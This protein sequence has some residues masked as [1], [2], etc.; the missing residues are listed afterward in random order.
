[1]FSCRNRR[2]KS[3]GDHWN[4]LPRYHVFSSFHGP[5][6][7]NGFLSHLHNHFESKGITTFNDQ[8]IE[9]G[10][11]IGPELVQAIRESRVSIVVLSEKY[12]SSGWCLDELVE[13][14]KCKEASGQA[15]L[16]IFYK[17]D[18]S[19][20]RKQRGD[21][22]NTFKK[23]C[24]GK[25]EE[26]KQRWIKA[27]TD[28]A[29]IAGEHSLN[30]ANEAEMIQ[31]IATDVSNKL[32]VTPSRDFEGMVGLEA[33]L[34]K[35][36][37]LLCLE[38]NDVKMIGIWGPAGIG[39]TTI[40]RA[41]FN[42]LSTGFRHSCFMGN[43]DV[44]NYDSKLRLHNMLLSKILNQK[45]MKIHHLG[46]IKEW[47]HNQRVL[48]VL[49]DVDD[50]E[51]LE[52]LAKESF[53]FG[54]RSRIIVTLKDKKILKA[55][56]INDIYHVDYPSKKEAL[57]IFCLSAFKQSSPQDGFEEFA[58]KVVELCGNLPLALCVVGS[59]FYGESEDEWRLQLY[60][61]EINLD[62][63]VE[64]VLR[65]GY[66]KLLE[67]HQ[68]LF[69]HIACFFN[70][71]SV[72]YVSTM[73]ADS[74]LDVENGLKN[75]AAKSL[76]HIST[77][78]RI[79][80]HCLLQQLGRHVVVQQSGEQ[81]KRQFLVEAKEIRDVLANKT[82]TGSVIGISFDMSKIGEF[83]ISKRAFERMCNL[84]FLKFY[85]GNVSLL[86]DM[87]YLPRLRLLHWDS[88]PR[89]SLPLT[90][91]PECLVELHMRYSKL[92][93]LWGGIQPL[94]NLKKIDLGY[95]FNL[96]EIPNLSKATNLETLKL[97]GCE[98]LVVLPSSIRNLHKLEMLDA[99]GCSKLQVIPTNIDLASLEEVKMD[100]C[101]R[102][103]SF[104]DI[105]RNIEYLSVA[106]TKIKEFPASIVGYWSRL[107]IL[108]IGSRSLK[109]LTHVPQSVKSLDLSN[110]DIKMIPDY[111][112][113]LPHLG[114]L[115]VDNCRKLVSIQGHFPSLA[116]LSAEHCISLKSVCCSFHRPISNLMFH[117]CLKLDNASKRG[118]VQLSG[119]KSIC[120]PGKEIPAEFTHQTR[121][122]SITISL[123]PGGKEVFSVFSRFKAC[124][125]LSPI[126]NFAFNKINCIL[127]SREGVKINCTTQSIYTFV[128]GRSLSEHL[129]MFCGDLFPEENGCLMD[130]T[131]NE[132][133]FEFS[134]SDDNVMAC[135]VKILA[136]DGQSSS[137][138][139]VGY[140]ETEGNRNHRIDGE[141]KALKV[142]QVNNIKNS[143]HTGD[144]SWLR[145]LLLGKK[146]MKR[147]KTELSLTPVSG[148]SDDTQG[149]LMRYHHPETVQL[150]KEENTTDLS[151]LL[152]IVSLVFSVL[153]IF[154]CLFLQMQ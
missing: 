106:G 13:I 91:Q 46:A 2:T 139:E 88:Y 132:I 95:S 114:Y 70:H 149:I 30:W 48:I 77:H 33:H 26:V 11:T 119:Y 8:E 3:I 32:N 29:T 134:S 121:G 53:W 92:E 148:S 21:F 50:L 63:K 146:K 109:R 118:I 78:G 84:K 125:L 20:V 86:E 150:S 49:D 85:N 145:K 102:L 25:T 6:V 40:A 41:L 111:V 71:E 144:W 143:K 116:S 113:G 66:D 138:I 55:H 115:N 93:M 15:V 16:T 128:C 23:T 64:D 153:L 43:I 37:S 99:S 1:M 89:K 94:A 147:N 61:I 38:C 151:R 74:T 137:G 52:V 108:Q 31:K 136:E 110:S 127:R 82:G 44:N 56:G 47:L 103:R 98:S 45:D 79:R 10:H 104:P 54:P 142:S 42:Q 130:V 59:S 124:L 80:M 18:P 69:L 22:G 14:L 90:F 73:L 39:K 36:D 87:K 122:N 12:A 107:D 133:Q 81:G 57:E 35:L 135:G 152:C 19:D 96:K 97:I 126:K 120:L 67:K 83:S 7:R 105:S 5:D 58:R 65:V 154:H 100:N 34:T 28:V 101:S 131:P 4:W 75:L 27:L 51:Q 129:L 72:D 17:V 112:I 141:A 9:R 60:G 76:V 24:E 140:S 62:R 68:S 117:N 123:A